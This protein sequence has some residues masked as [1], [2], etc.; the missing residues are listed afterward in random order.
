MRKAIGFAIKL[1]VSQMVAS[2]AERNCIGRARGLFLEQLVDQ[3]IVRIIGRGDVEEPRDLV[4]FGFAHQRQCGDRLAHVA[5]HRCQ[6]RPEMV[7][8]AFDRRGVEQVAHVVDIARDPA[9]RFV[10]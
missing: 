8:P 6:H 3:A 9:S 5:R 4:K 10:Q 2:V 1:G 7:D